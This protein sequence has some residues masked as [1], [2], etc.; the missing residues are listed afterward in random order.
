LIRIGEYGAVVARVD[1]D[2]VVVVAG[3]ADTVVVEIVLRRVGNGGTHV[4]VVV[5]FI[6]IEVG[7]DAERDHDGV[8]GLVLVT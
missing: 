5:D 8:P 4:D 6:A 7:A 1:D 3:A 2:D